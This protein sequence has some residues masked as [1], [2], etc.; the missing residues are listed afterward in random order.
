MFPEAEEKL[1]KTSS[2]LE[3]SRDLLLA[4]IERYLT[5]HDAA[6]RVCDNLE[7]PPDTDQLGEAPGSSLLRRLAGVREA[8]WD[9]VRSTLQYG[10]QVALAV[11]RSAYVCNISTVAEG[12]FYEPGMTSAETQARCDELMAEAEAPS[13]SLAQR[14]EAFV[15]YPRDLADDDDDEAPPAGDD[16]PPADGDEAP[17][18][19]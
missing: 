2:D 1:G 8:V 14:F 6:A 5:L 15:R 19:G 18:E 13:E 11:V 12:F 10:M 16:L 9:Q 4:E 7:V 17:R 3:E